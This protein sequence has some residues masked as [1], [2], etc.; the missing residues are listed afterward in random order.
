MINVIQ[1]QDIIHRKPIPKPWSE[2]D[3]IPWNDPAFSA[4]MLNEHLSQDHDAASRRFKVIDMHVSWIDQH[5]LGGVVSKILDLGC[6]PGLYATRLA[7]LGHQ[8]VGIDYSPASIDYA[9]EC[10]GKDS[11][12]C[13]FFEADI[14]H[15]EYGAGFDA[16]MLIYGEFNVF[17]PEDIQLILRKVYRGLNPGGLL[18]LEPHTFLA[19]QDLGEQQPSWHSS[20][21]GLFAD[22]PYILLQ[23]FSWIEGSQVS[24][25]RYY[26]I[27]ADGRS[28]LR[29]F[30]SLQ[31][32]TRDSYQSLL[33][34]NGYT[35]VRYFPS[36]TGEID[37]GQDSLLAIIAEKP[38]GLL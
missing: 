24:N 22:Q 8:I 35:N 29:Y 25:I 5:V 15:A 9:R 23:E 7:K 2:G 12:N 37:P 26:I 10:A 36:L 38:G 4:R 32:Y 20:P 1:F 31:A 13:S 3:N 6:G 28:I 30:Q 21:S 16:A 33:E 27:T 11:L 19:I 14:R 18:I 34:D 17:R